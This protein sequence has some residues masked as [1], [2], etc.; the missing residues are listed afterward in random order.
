[1]TQMASSRNVSEPL[2]SDRLLPNASYSIE[3]IDF[4]EISVFFEFVT[5]Y[6]NSVN[7]KIDIIKYQ[8]NLFSY[9]IKT[10][11]EFCGG[12]VYK[13]DSWFW[14]Y[15]FSYKTLWFLCLIGHFW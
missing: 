8:S 13:D 10:N 11:F 5:F 15:K 4:N 12:L 9:R 3:C 2:T 7:F 14:Y 1:M 6:N